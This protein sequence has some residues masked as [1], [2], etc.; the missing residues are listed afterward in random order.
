MLN[1]S[2]KIYLTRKTQIIFIFINKILIFKKYID[3]RDIFF[4]K[5][6]KLLLKYIKTNKQAIEL[7]KK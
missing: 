4:K 6:V 3:L 2:I 7:E 1:S 5:S